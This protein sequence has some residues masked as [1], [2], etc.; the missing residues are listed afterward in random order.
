MADNFLNLA[1]IGTIPDFA[2]I[3]GLLVCLELPRVYFSSFVL[4]FK[5]LAGMQFLVNG[6]RSELI[7]LG[8]WLVMRGENV[9]YDLILVA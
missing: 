8:T 2:S 1:V 6:L 5:K 7:K 9:N 3:A 4:S